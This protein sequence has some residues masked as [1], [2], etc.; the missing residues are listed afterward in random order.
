[1]KRTFDLSACSWTLAGTTP[2]AW[3][4][5]G[6]G[7]V[8]KR[9]EVGP[10]PAPV[11]GSVQKALLDAGIIPDWNEGLNA[12]ACEWVENRHWG[13]Q[14]AI[15][16]DWLAG[17]GDKTVRL[18]CLG[19]DYAGWVFCNEQ[20]A[21]TFCGSYIPHIFDLTPHLQAKDN[22]LAIVFDCPPRWLGQFG[23]T[24]RMKEWK[25]RFNY[26]WDWTSRL[27][28][29]GVWD[30]ITLEVAG[31]QE[32]EAVQCWADFDLETQT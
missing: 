8:E 23:Y 2:Y 30:A 22:R 15:P 31:A 21:G 28:Q 29:I 1:M 5:G 16:D 26:T 12:R 19:L 4:F 14:T 6:D 11:P 10:V 20:E 25:P 32:I 13:Y 24:S 3:R 17:V 9:F 7:F 18:R 27:V